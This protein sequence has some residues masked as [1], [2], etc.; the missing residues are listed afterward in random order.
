LVHEPDRSNASI[1]W[2]RDSRQNEQQ[3]RRPLLRVFDLVPED[4]DSLY[5]GLLR[6][7]PA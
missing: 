5:A 6:V 2:T 3:G 4:G 7:E 1:E